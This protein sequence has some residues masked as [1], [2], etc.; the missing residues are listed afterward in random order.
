[1]SCSDNILRLQYCILFILFIC[2]GYAVFGR[3]TQGKDVVD[4][5]ERVAT[6]SRGIHKDVPI[7]PIVI[8]KITIL[9]K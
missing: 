4:K 2:T 1:M 6:T 3:V 7:S 9:N 5:I 8:R